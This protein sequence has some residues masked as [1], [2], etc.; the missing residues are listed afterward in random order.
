MPQSFDHSGRNETLPRAILH[1][2]PFDAAR[3]INID[4]IVV[5]VPPDGERSHKDGTLAYPPVFG[6][7]QGH[8]L[9]VC[10]SIAVPAPL[11]RDSWCDLV[12]YGSLKI[13]T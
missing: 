8:W 5:I 4:L 13:S 6:A 2:A 1:A 3:K 11:V 7:G 12:I 9:L 10:R